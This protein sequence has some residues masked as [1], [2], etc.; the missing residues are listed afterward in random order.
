[1]QNNI[2]G[3][4]GCPLIGNLRFFTKSGS[5][6]TGPGEF[7]RLQSKT[8][9]NPSI[10]KYMA[11]SK[12]IVMV[13]GMKNVKAAFNTE[14]K[15]ISTGTILKNFLK[16]FGASSLLFVTDP[17]K[18]QYLRRLVGQSMTPDAINKAIPALV[19]G[20]NEQIDYI[21]VGSNVTME[22][23]FTNYTL[24]VAWRQILGLDLKDDEIE[25]FGVK[26]NEWIGGITSLRTM[27]FPGVRYTTA[28]KAYAYLSSKIESK[29]DDLSKNGPDGSTLSGMF[30]AKDEEDPTKQLNREEVI[31]NALLLILAGSETAASTLTVA[32]L[33]LGL[34]KGAFE[35]L[36]EEQREMIAKRGTTEITREM[37]DKDCPYLD[38]VIKETMRIKPLATGAMR[39]AQ[40][41]I[42]VDGKQIPKGYGVAFNAYLTHESDPA[43]KVEDNSHM[44]VVKGFHPERWLDDATKPSE[45]MPFGYGPRFC[46]GYN[47][48][49]AE[50][51]VFLAL[52]ARRVVEYDLVNNS[53]DK[54]TWKRASILPKPADGA[55]IVVS[56]LR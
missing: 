2:I 48:A 11:F 31:S 21:S 1:M 43:T 15:K 55:V 8:V 16:L 27:M 12:P 5:P 7:F 26:V 36:K 6:E 29:M 17:E 51:K 52:F 9:D 37:L 3:S 40:E 53:P 30:F 18:H 14:F 54:V 47:L 22:A 41:T 23:A 28:G 35:K 50:M 20:A 39:F 33:A 13:S 56:S 19:K 25:E 49:M 46:L 34:H 32:S 4:L 10:F 38:S 44:D 42:V 45:F 24:D